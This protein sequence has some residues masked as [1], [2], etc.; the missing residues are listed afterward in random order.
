MKVPYKM[1]PQSA[2]VPLDHTQFVVGHP[3]QIKGLVLKIQIKNQ[4]D[5]V[6][7]ESLLV[8]L[9][10]DKKMVE[11]KFE[12][13]VK[14]ANKV[15]KDLTAERKDTL[16]NYEMAEK[17]IKGKMKEFHIESDRKA[18]EELSEVTITSLAPPELRSKLKHTTFVTKYKF[19]VTDPD[20][21]PAEYLTPDLEKISRKVNAMGEM[22]KI[23]GV[24]VYRDDE[25][26][27]RT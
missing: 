20:K 14:Q 21:L 5:L 1:E 22:A 18:L 4:V 9:M 12:E 7:T 26:R 10:T 11:K 25:V 13:P 24:T 15:H 19:E 8:N 16:K 6:R 2:M 27:V 23:K 17:L 3:D